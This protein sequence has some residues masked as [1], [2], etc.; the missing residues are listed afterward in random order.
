[1]AIREF[2]YRGLKLAELQKLNDKEFIALL[3]ARQR[4]SFARDEDPKL[5]KLIE[6]I[7]RGKKNIET[8]CRT[9]I[10][11]PDMVGKT[12]KIHNG[13]EFVAVIIQ[14]EMIGH[15][16]GEFSQTRKKV[17]HSSPGIGATKSSSAVSVR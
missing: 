15:V 12:I 3:P 8:H 5:K 6:D 11:R 14:D 17:G 4:R 16:L 1:M 10:V 13:K 9:F 7:R 2:T